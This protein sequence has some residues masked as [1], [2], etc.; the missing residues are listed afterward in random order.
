MRNLKKKN[1]L[2]LDKNIDMNSYGSFFV[3]I[4][5]I[6]VYIFIR[7]ANNGNFES[8]LVKKKTKTR[9]TD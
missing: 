1:R 4:L 3:V 8:P 5:Y 9:S 7:P 6:H 2:T